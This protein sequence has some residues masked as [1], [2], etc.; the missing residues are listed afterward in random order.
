LIR[1]IESQLADAR[2][3]EAALNA[4]IAK[5]QDI[6]NRNTATITTI[7]SKITAL[8][9]ETRQLRDELDRIRA[10]NTDL[11]I[12]VERLRTDLN[13][14]NGK[15]DKYRA[16]IRDL[17]VKLAAEKKKLPSDDL[18]SLNQ[19]IAALKKFIPTIQT[20]IDRHYYYCY[21]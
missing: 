5:S 6:I 15:A 3:R 2:S 19:M 11:E 18:D 7:R 10:K 21:G 4:S 8:E 1:E 14:A 13:V 17:E 16:Q 9:T 12:K 20:E